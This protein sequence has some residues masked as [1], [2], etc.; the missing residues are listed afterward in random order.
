[1]MTCRS[2]K[3][4][5]ISRMMNDAGMLVLTR[6]RDILVNSL[7]DADSGL[8]DIEALIQDIG[9]GSIERAAFLR[10]QE[11]RQRLFD[12]RNALQRLAL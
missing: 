10:V 7:D 2:E 12:A 11:A 4:S 1:M 5:A 6:A 9:W 3:P 8:S